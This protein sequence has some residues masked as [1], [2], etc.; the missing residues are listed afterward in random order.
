MCGIAGII[1]V[2]DGAA[3]LAEMLSRIEHRGDRPT[4]ILDVAGTKIGINRLAIVDIDGGKQPLSN[5]DGTLHVVF[6]GEIYNHTALREELVG[7]GHRFKTQ[8]DTEVI[9][10]GFEEYGEAILHRLDGKFAFVLYDS[11]AG[12]YFGARDFLGVKPLYYALSGGFAF[13]S[14]LKAFL[15][16]ALLPDVKSLPPGHCISNGKVA[17]YYTIPRFRIERDEAGMAD[18]LRALITAAVHKRVQTELPVGVFLSGGL[19]SSIILALAVQ[20]HRRI[21]AYSIGYP[22]SEDL[23][24]AERLAKDLGVPHEVY[25]VL[26]R[27]L[28]DLTEVMRVTELFEPL[29]VKNAV[30]SYLAARLAARDGM[31]IVLVGEGS[32]ELF[33][34]YSDFLH[35]SEPDAL[36]MRK[37]ANMHRTELQRTDRACMAHRI[38]ARVPFLDRAVVEYAVNVPFDVKLREGMDKHFLRRVFSSLLPEHILKRRK[39]PFFVGANIHEKIATL[40]G[41]SLSGYNHYAPDE[42]ELAAFIERYRALGYPVPTE[43]CR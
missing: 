5:E 38:E 23:V 41:A 13:A 3:G 25:T 40:H 4:E 29:D 34:G 31:K 10:H 20:R 39:V 11:R 9:L 21:T 24:Y 42:V 35:S 8:A 27:D 14:E 15:G 43:R 37:L 33:G 32:D 12:T 6:N 18:D 7:R 1:G 26:D 17:R 2:R 22:G 16:S 19:D 30:S 36:M 28:S